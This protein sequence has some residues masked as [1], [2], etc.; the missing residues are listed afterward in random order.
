MRILAAMRCPICSKQPPQGERHPEHP[1]C[2]ERC[3]L[4]DL[5]RWLEGDYVIPGPP[6]PADGLTFWPEDPGATD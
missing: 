5:G 4:I 1:F 2:S 6:S 3:K